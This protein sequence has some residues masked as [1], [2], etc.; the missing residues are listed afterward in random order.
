MRIVQKGDEEPLAQVIQQ[1]WKQLC[2]HTGTHSDL[3]SIEAARHVVKWETHDPDNVS[4][5]VITHGEEIVGLTFLSKY[6]DKVHGAEV[7]A[8]SPN[9]QGKALGRF[10]TNLLIRKTFKSLFKLL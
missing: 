1:A 2:K 9:H 8:V 4:G 6:C 7:I 10:L 5:W 3:E